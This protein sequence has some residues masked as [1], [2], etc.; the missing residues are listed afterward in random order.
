[1][2]EK[3]IP[4][5]KMPGHC[6][7]NLVLFSMSGK[8]QENVREMSGKGQGKVRE[9]SGKGQGKVR[10]ICINLNKVF[11][12]SNTAKCFDSCAIEKESLTTSKGSLKNT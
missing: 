8:C 7:G 4:S 3:S 10:E 12:V 6:Q 11:D 2:E 5:Q 9:R 1:M